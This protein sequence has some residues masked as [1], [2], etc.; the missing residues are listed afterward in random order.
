[1]VWCGVVV[2]KGIKDHHNHPDIER[3]K[4]KNF[5][6]SLKVYLLFVWK[7]TMHHDV[8]INPAELV[9]DIKWKGMFAREKCR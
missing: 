3:I 8:I 5:L 4:N 9:N 7:V 1:M 2:R 6:F